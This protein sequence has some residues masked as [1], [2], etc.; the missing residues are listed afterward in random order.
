MVFG[1]NHKAEAKKAADT[2]L[3]ASKIGALR[4]ELAEGSTDASDDMD[5]AAEWIDKLYESK[6]Q[7][8]RDTQELNEMAELTAKITQKLSVSKEDGAD[9]MDYHYTRLWIKDFSP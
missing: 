5:L 4:A 2:K 7:K 9:P 3:L 6:K 1:H 8:L